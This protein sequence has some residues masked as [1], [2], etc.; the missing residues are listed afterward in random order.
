MESR[1][2]D[3]PSPPPPAPDQGRILDRKKS[4]R[5]LPNSFSSNLGSSRRQSPLNK[6]CTTPRT[7]SGATATS[8]PAAAAA[9]AAAGNT[10]S[11][12][13][14][15]IVDWLEKT[16]GSGEG[17]RKKSSVSSGSG[18]GSG[19]GSTA[20]RKWRHIGTGAE[21]DDEPS[22]PVVPTTPTT[23]LVPVVLAEEYS[24]TLL[25]HKQYLN[26]RPLGRCL[27]DGPAGPVGGSGRTEG[28][29]TT[30]FVHR[31]VKKKKQDNETELGRIGDE[32]GTKDS[33]VRVPDE[34]QE[35]YNARSEQRQRQSQPTG[36]EAGCDPPETVRRDLAEVR[37][38]WQ[39]VCATMYISDWELD[40]ASS[41]S[42]PTS[43]SS[44][45]SSRIDL[46]ERMTNAAGSPRQTFSDEV[47][48][49]PLM[50]SS[51][52]TPT[53]G[54]YSRHHPRQE[55][56]AAASTRRRASGQ[57]TG[58]SRTPPRRPR[59]RLTTEEKLS[60]IDEFLH[61]QGG[62]EKRRF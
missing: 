5:G 7:A 53:S 17:A 11:S 47:G 50:A 35:I 4:P 39:S 20:A 49:A 21:G 31:P 16:R 24:L 25:K 55:T 44:S 30:V 43:T 48:I 12:G 62:G 8:S 9:A 57:S 13:V 33:A 18:S 45:F 15:A 2:H 46:M 59:R 34:M 22:S 41:S 19:S 60:E 26:N 54:G 14:K 1:H 10:P 42:A 23:P 27:D 29:K 58:S 37:A 51:S 52:P 56:T 61:S 3:A 36:G 6:A 28:S 38:Y 40:N 32:P